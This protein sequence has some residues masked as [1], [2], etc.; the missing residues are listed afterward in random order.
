MG[1]PNLAK[2]VTTGR[3]FPVSGDRPKPKEPRTTKMLD[4]GYG[5]IKATRPN[6]SAIV[7]QSR[8]A[9]I[10]RLGVLPPKSKY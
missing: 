10:R 5:N 3:S 1:K 7:K 6:E 9:L 4:D 2:P 8:A